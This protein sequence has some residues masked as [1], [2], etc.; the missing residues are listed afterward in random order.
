LWLQFADA[1]TGET[2]FRHCKKKNCGKLILISTEDGSRTNKQTC[3]DNCRVQVN[4]TRIRTAIASFDQGKPPND[5]A[6]GLETELS[7]VLKWIARELGKRGDTVSTIS[8]RLFVKPGEVRQLL[9][10][11]AASRDSS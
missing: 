8:R 10:K 4:Q 2:E 1:L 7:T 9:E 3:S 5:I 11:K 6:I